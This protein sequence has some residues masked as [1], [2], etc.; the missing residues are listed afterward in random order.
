MKKL[1]KQ[2]KGLFEKDSDQI[3]IQYREF[4]NRFYSGEV[5]KK[6]EDEDKGEVQY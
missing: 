2:N 1:T 6:D 3:Y 4:A 5:C